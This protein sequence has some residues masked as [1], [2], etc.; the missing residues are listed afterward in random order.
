MDEHT[1]RIFLPE[2]FAEPS[3]VRRLRPSAPEPV[4]VPDDVVSRPVQLFART[5]LPSF[6]DHVFPYLTL[7]EITPYIE[8]PLPFEHPDTVRVIEMVKTLPFEPA[9]RW[10]AGLQR[11]LAS[12]PIDPEFQEMLAR[13]VYLGRVGDLFARALRSYNG[14]AVVISEPQL[15]ALQR[16]LV[17][18]AREDNADDLTPEQHAALRTALASIPGTILKEADEDTRVH[19]QDGIDHLAP[20]EWLRFFIGSGGLTQ[21]AAFDHALARAHRIYSVIANSRAARRHPRYCPFESWLRETYEGLGFTDLQAAGLAALAGSRMFGGAEEP[22]LLIEPGYFAPSAL[23]SK[24]ETIFG[25]LSTDRE[26]LKAMFE[27]SP[28]T[29]RRQA[30]EILPFLQYPALRQADGRAMVIAPRAIQGWLSPAGAYWRLFHIAQSKGPRWKTRFFHFH[31]FL[32]ERYVLQLSYAAH[33]DQRRRRLLRTAGIVHKETP[34]KQDGTS[35]TS[36]VIVDNG[37]DVVLIEATAK[38]LTIPSIL[39]AKPHNI[40]TDLQAMIVE[41]VEQLGRVMRDLATGTAALDTVDAALVRTFWPVLVTPDNSLQTPT[42][43]DYIDERCEQFLTLPR[44]QCTQTIGPLVLL[45]VEEYERLMGLVAEGASLVEVLRR[46]TN[47]LWR[48]RDFKSLLSD[49]IMRFGSG[50]NEF[51]QQELHRAM[52]AIKRSLQLREPHTEPAQQRQ[53]A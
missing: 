24:S 51:V 25:A 17:L 20:E 13:E 33:P 38:R 52:R 36:D 7:E 15:F 12:S 11:V 48:H 30:R 1:F 8:S 40:E 46:K 41:K 53:A 18:H 16:L 21:N 47:E 28:Q 22:P 2:E 5:T 3:G 44:P 37:T 32:H 23:A 42:L 10:V 34:Y 35:L 31:G 39:D 4:R 49:D 43:W 9:M 19:E 45:E 14:H 27:R 6:F 26:T 29:A 50:E